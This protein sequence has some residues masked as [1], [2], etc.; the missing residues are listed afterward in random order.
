MGALGALGCEDSALTT[1]L[2]YKW[3]NESWGGLLYKRAISGTLA[4]LTRHDTAKT[5]LAFELSS[6]QHQKFNKPLS[7]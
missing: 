7:F 2:I 3:A 1:G 5:D 6:Q 4:P